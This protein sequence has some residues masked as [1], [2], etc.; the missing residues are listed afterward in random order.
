M[1]DIKSKIREMSNLYKELFESGEDVKSGK[2]LIGVGGEGIVDAEDGEESGGVAAAED[3]V[4]AGGEMKAV[5]FMRKVGGGYYVGG[6][7]RFR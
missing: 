1:S 2:R 3:A 5:A 7:N 6:G 4:A